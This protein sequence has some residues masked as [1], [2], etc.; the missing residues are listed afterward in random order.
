MNFSTLHQY[1]VAFIHTDPAHYDVAPALHT[2]EYSSHKRK[3][4]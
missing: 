1:F 4:P 3:F 2:W